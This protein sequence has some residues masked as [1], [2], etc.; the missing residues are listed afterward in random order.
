MQ[1]ET[2]VRITVWL[3]FRSS[4]PEVFCKKGV[5]KNFTKFTGKHLCQ[6]LYFN[7]KLQ[8]F[9][10]TKVDQISTKESWDL[11]VKT[12]PSPRSSYADL[13]KVNTV[14]EKWL[15]FF[16]KKNFPMYLY[17]ILGATHYSH[18]T[19]LWQEQKSRYKVLQKTLKT[20]YRT[21][22]PLI[23]TCTSFI[24]ELTIS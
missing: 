12:N 5:F 22:D 18:I 15:W 24:T 21:S 20:Y 7:I 6:S 17:K 16:K 19:H 1:S 11:L 4:R 23:F 9:H 2:Q 10:P 13:G 14:H 3:I 8:A